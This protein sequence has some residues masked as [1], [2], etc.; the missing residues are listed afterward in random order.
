[1]SKIKKVDN[2]ATKDGLNNPQPRINV[3]NTT[4]PPVLNV[5]R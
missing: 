4:P 5:K 1:M 2:N 3:L